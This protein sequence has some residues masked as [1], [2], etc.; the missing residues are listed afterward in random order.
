M[1]VARGAMDGKSPATALSSL[2]FRIAISGEE[3]GV[4]GATSMASSASK[5]N[6]DGAAAAAA[7]LLK[8]RPFAKLLLLRMGSASSSSLRT[9]HVPS[10]LNA[11]I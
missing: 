7:E 4:L 5:L 10:A 8:S 2:A 3:P 11:F 9:T 1:C 6:A